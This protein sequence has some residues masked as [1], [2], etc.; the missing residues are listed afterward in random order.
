[1]KTLTTQEVR[2]MADL[3]DAYKTMQVPADLERIVG[4]SAQ[5][6]ASIYARDHALPIAEER[7][8]LVAKVRRFEEREAHWCSVL[9]VTDGGRFRTD[10]DSRIRAL[11]SE[12]DALRAERDALAAEVQR[13]Q[14]QKPVRWM[15]I[16]P[17]GEHYGM[18][19]EPSLHPNDISRG[20][21]IAPL[22][23]APVVRD[24]SG[25]IAQCEAYLAGDYEL[26]E[27]RPNPHDVV[28][29]A[30]AVLRGAS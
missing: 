11:V 1:M 7:D 22:Y 12:R 16:G 2:G 29:A 21:T 30:L 3:V 8:A 26:G 24:V 6:G 4:E 18:I 28:S 14:K 19:T 9:G 13:S 17:G 5:V 23:F 10:W 15:M 20:W 27:P 25:V